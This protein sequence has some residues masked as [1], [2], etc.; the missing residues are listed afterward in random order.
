M[1][2]TT[3][4]LCT[5]LVFDLET[6]SIARDVNLCSS[7]SSDLSLK[8][9]N[10]QIVLQI[11][12]WQW[13]HQG[14]NWLLGDCIYK[15]H[16]K[17]ARNKI[18]WMDD[19]QTLSACQIPEKFSASPS[20]VNEFCWLFQ[21]CI[22]IRVFVYGTHRLDCLA[23]CFSCT[24]RQVWQISQSDTA[25]KLELSVI[26]LFLLLGFIIV[27]DII[28]VLLLLSYC[29][30][31][32][33]ELHVGGTPGQ[34]TAKLALPLDILIGTPQK[35]FQHAQQGHLAFG[36]VQYVVLDE[37]DTMFDKGFG[38]EVKAI[39]HPVR[40]KENPATCILVLAT[41]HKV[42]IFCVLSQ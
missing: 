14:L 11:N 7:V 32:Q 35:I 16:A 20:V 42:T 17:F 39:L 10:R 37:A 5:R 36:D 21:G 1:W 22:Q 29:I 27:V 18:D 9:I 30:S 25:S 8:V 3:T 28:T 13:Q 4:L 31:N 12:P 19:R 15:L 6:G 26:I 24:S 23:R 38:P 33:S 41:M 40:S 2:H 34:Q